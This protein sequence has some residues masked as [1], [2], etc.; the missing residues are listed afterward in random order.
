MAVLD[1]SGTLGRADEWSR[2]VLLPDRCSALNAAAACLTADES[3]WQS[4]VT[5]QASQPGQLAVGQSTIR[6][7][8]CPRT[9]CRQARKHRWMASAPS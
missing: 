9:R 2:L 1:S 7:R 3:V 5:C 8:Q 4:G 6:G